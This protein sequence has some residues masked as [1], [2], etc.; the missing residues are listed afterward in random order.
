M[1]AIDWTNAHFGSLLLQIFLIENL[2]LLFTI[3]VECNWSFV[4]FEWCAFTIEFS[5]TFSFSCL[6]HLLSPSSSLI[7][8]DRQGMRAA[9]CI[10]QSTRCVS[11]GLAC[12][13][14]ASA[15]SIRCYHA[16]SML[17]WW[18]WW[19]L[20]P[21]VLDVSKPAARSGHRWHWISLIVAIDGG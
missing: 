20:I 14:T 2:Q 8:G 16:S 21:H 10:G 11:G 12:L 18:W 17:V 7:R 15:R 6:L 19:Q 13:P 4:K 1:L 5:I 3:L 9:A